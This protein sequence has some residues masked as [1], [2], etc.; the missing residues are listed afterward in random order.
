M[1]HYIVR[2]YRRKRKQPRQVVGVVEDV[3]TGDIQAFHNTDELEVIMG[4]APKRVSKTK[5]PRR[6]K[7]DIEPNT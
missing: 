1:D 3:A 2:I 5:T 4:A 7:P 6:R